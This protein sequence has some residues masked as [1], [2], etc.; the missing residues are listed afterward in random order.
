MRL[1]LLL[2]A[3]LSAVVVAGNT[4]VL[5]NLPTRFSVTVP[6]SMDQASSSSCAQAETEKRR[7]LSSSSQP[8]FSS[9]AVPIPMD[10]AASRRAQKI[11]TER[12]KTSSSL[13][14]AKNNG[15]RRKLLSMLQQC[16]KCFPGSFA[17][18]TTDGE[19][20]ILCPVG[21]YATLEGSSSCTPCPNGTT[22]AEPGSFF[23]EQCISVTSAAGVVEEAG[24]S[25]PCLA[26]FS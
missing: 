10:E 26:S 18:G 7:A 3:V 15:K 13:S 19:S 2:A 17:D 11:R 9:I 12:K 22:T 6:I 8:F 5:H 14:I 1:I 20:C 16:E 25:N 21:T 23:L 4:N 24:G